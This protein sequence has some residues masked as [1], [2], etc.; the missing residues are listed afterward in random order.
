MDFRLIT[1][2]IRRMGQG[3]V[4][5]LSVHTSTGAGGGGVTGGQYP[6]PCPDD[7]GRG[8]PIPGLGRKGG[9]DPIP[10]LGRKGIPHPADWGGTPKQGRGYPPPPKLR[11]GWG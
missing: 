1:A 7:K 9:G 10:G 11:T 5:S 3:T 2:R 8:D 4:F 6:I